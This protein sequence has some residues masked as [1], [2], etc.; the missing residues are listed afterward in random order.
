MQPKVFNSNLGKQIS[1]LSSREWSLLG[2]DTA[3]REEFTL[4][5]VKKGECIDIV[6]KYK[7]L[8]NS[9]SMNFLFQF[10]NEPAE[11]VYGV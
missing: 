4:M 7:L 8:F 11:R 3:S 1:E 5:L 6:Q 9:I 10:I 2:C